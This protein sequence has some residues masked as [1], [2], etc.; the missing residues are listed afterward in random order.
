MN[1]QFKECNRL[2]FQLLDERDNVSWAIYLN[3]ISGINHIE[4]YFKSLFVFDRKNKGNHIHLSTE[5]SFFLARNI[6]SPV[7]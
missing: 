4:K 1:S 2:D 3:K 5:T 6:V 7:A